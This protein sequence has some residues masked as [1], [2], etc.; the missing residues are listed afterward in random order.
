[1]NIMKNTQPTTQIATLQAL[2]LV[3][4][5]A[6]TVRLD[7]QSDAG[8]VLSAG[9]LLLLLDITAD[10]SSTTNATLDNSS[11]ST[12][13]VNEGVVCQ[14]I[15]YCYGRDLYVVG[16]DLADHGLYA[17]TPTTLDY[18]STYITGTLNEAAKLV[19]TSGVASLTDPR[20]WT[21]THYTLVDNGGSIL[22]TADQDYLLEKVD[23][24]GGV[25][26]TDGGSGSSNAALMISSVGTGQI[27]NLDLHGITAKNLQKSPCLRPSYPPAFSQS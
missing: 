24:S 21:F 16:N 26:D 10:A 17:L 9:G 5:Q 12:A 2:A 7:G 8:I 6:L 22:V 4:D 23:L 11:G 20:R 1:M 3:A 18:S 15:T 13:V 27:R 14:R 25:I 19:P